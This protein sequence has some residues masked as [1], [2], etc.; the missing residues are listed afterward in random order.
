MKASAHGDWY[1][2]T[3]ALVKMLKHGKLNGENA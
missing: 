3:A 1:R 2:L